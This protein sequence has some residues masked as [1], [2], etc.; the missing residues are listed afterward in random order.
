M[1]LQHATVVTVRLAEHQL[2]CLQLSQHLVHGLWRD[3][4]SAR[5]FSVGQAR[6]LIERYSTAYWA[7]VTP[8]P[9]NAVVRAPARPLCTRFNE[10][11]LFAEQAGQQRLD[12]RRADAHTML[13]KKPGPTTV[14]FHPNA[15]SRSRSASVSQRL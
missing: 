13:A 5:E 15:A 2:T 6:L 9:L 4:R 7:R 11:G 12:Q 8:R 10:L 1:G 14:I 3:E